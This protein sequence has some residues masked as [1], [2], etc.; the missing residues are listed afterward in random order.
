[1]GGLWRLHGQLLYM[2]IENAQ[3]K[4]CKAIQNWNLALSQLAIHYEGRLDSYLD[5]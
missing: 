4:W 3:K 5:L 1:M 2:G